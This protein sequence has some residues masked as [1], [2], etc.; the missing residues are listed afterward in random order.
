[1]IRM[2]L[3]TALSM[4]IAGPLLAQ[5][6]EGP[7]APGGPAIPAPS[8][9][10]GLT[11]PTSIELLPGTFEPDPFHAA[12][13]DFDKRQTFRQD[14]PLLFEAVVSSG[15]L[16]PPVDQLAASIQIELKRMGC[17]DIAVDGDFGPR[18]REAVRRYYT[19]RD[20]DPPAV[21]TATFDLFRL[22]V[23]ADDVTCAPVPVVVRQPSSPPPV[24]SPPTSPPSSQIQSPPSSSE[25]E[26]NFNIIIH[27]GGRG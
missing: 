8:I 1:M 7:V 4:A 2:V 13:S 25:P 17:Y 15:A 5:G 9:L 18:S 14:D 21:A 3:V 20:V 11:A 27:G 19:A 24:S 22:I 10:I 26:P 12:Y 16:D 23:L 6:V